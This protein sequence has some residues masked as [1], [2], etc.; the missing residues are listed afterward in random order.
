MIQRVQLQ[1]QQ[2]PQLNQPPQLSV[3]AKKLPSNTM[4]FCSRR[5]LQQLP[6]FTRH[7]FSI[8]ELQQRAW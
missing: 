5:I 6:V 8:S 4:V 7:L 3:K 1:Q 2:Q